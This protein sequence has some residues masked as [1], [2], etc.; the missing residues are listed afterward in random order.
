[1]VSRYL[2]ACRM[3][4][5][6][7]NR[8]NLKRNFTASSVELKAAAAATDPIQQLFADKVFLC[9]HAIKVIIK[10]VAIILFSSKTTE[11]LLTE[12]FV[13]IKGK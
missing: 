2:I 5:A 11:L 7:L 10:R 12:V 8:S 13:F 6:L 9:F 3:A 4:P 1:M